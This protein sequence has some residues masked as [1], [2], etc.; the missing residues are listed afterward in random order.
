MYA[1]SCFPRCLGW[2]QARS[3]ADV[4]W[5]VCWSQ[6]LLAGAYQQSCE[7]SQRVTELVILVSVIHTARLCG[8]LEQKA[9]SLLWSWLEGCEGGRASSTANLALG[10]SVNKEGLTFRKSNGA[11]ST[12]S[13]LSILELKSPFSFY[14]RSQGYYSGNKGSILCGFLDH[15]PCSSMQ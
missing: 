3:E 13:L 12:I 10:F 2:G 11:W 7:W 9:E 4:H 15:L 14:S 6:T 8:Q 1:G 5:N